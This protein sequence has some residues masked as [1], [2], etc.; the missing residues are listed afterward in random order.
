MPPVAAN[1]SRGSQKKSAS[2]NLS[3]TEAEQ[4]ILLSLTKD[5]AAV[6]DK[7]DILT[8]INPK[9][10]KLFGVDDIFVCRLH[11]NENTLNPVLRVGARVRYQ[12]PDFER[13]ISQN[14]PIHDGFIDTILNTHQ[15]LVFDI[16]EVNNWPHPPAYMKILSAAG[17]AESLSISLHHSG[18]TIGI[19][20]LW[21]GTKGTFTSR[22][23]KLI[24]NIA[25]NISIIIANI[26]Y[27]ENLQKR[28]SQNEILLSLS[29]EIASIRSKNDL[30][31]IIRDSIKKHVHFD[32]SYILRYDKDNH[33]CR[34]FIYHRTKNHQPVAE[35]EAQLAIDYPLDDTIA[36]AH[37]P[38]VYNVAELRQRGQQLVSFI[39]RQGIKE[40]VTIKLMHRNKIIG[41]LVLLSKKIASFSTDDLYLLQRISY[42]VSI[43]TANILANE[44]IEKREAEKSLLLSLSNDMAMVRNKE[45]LA[46]II[47][48]KLKKLFRI[49]DFTIVALHE[50][51]MTYGAYF[52]DQEDTPYKKKLEYVETLF[53]QFK[54][55][56]GLYDVVLSSEDP[57]VFNIGEIMQREQVPGHIRFFHSLGIQEIVGAA[58]RIGREDI[59]IL[60]IQPE[61]V[62]SFDTFN[63]RVF[64]GVSSQISIALANIIANENIQKR[65][66]EKSILL[67][68]SNE[69][70]AVRDKNGLFAVINSKV[71]ELFA[72]SGFAI[73][74]I[75]EDRKTHGAF[76]LDIEEQITRQAD[77]K[78]IIA[79]RYS[80]NDGVFDA[81]M[82]SMEPVTFNIANLEETPD[83]P[84][85]ASFWKK[86]GI[87]YIIG[88]PLRVG[89]NNMGCFYFHLGQQG[90]ET[91]RINLLKSVCSQLS[92]ALSNIISNEN[93]RKTHAENS[94]LLSFSN[95]LVT[96]KD[97]SGL[98]AIIKAYLKERFLIKE[99]IITVKNDDD[100]SYGYFLHDLQTDDPTDEGFKLITGPNMPIQGAMT[101]AVLQ[102]DEPV[103]FNLAEIEDRFS[104]PSA[105]FWRSTDAKE[106]M[107]MRL[108]I[109]GEDIGIL[110]TRPDQVTRRL[111]H[112]VSAQVAIA[113]S[114]II[115][116]EKN[117]NH[118]NEISNYKRQ[119]EDEKQYLQEEV[120]GSYT[121]SDII[122]TGPEMQ[123]LFRL[124]TQ[125][126]PSNSTVLLLGETGT[127]KEM[128]A[129]ALHNSSPRKNKLLVKVNCA[130]H[131]PNL[132]ESELFGHEKGSFTGATEL[133]IGKFE[134]ANNGTLFLDEIGEMPFDLQ[135]KLLRALQE[136]EIERVG[137]KV[138]IRTDVRIIAATNRDLQKEVLE[139]RFRSDL[140]YRLNVFPITL[141]PLRSRKEDIPLLAAHFIEKYARNA[142]KNIHS[143]S[144][145]VMNEL[146]AYNWP[147]NVREL[148]HL[149]ERSLLLTRGNTIKEIHLP[150]VG[151]KELRKTAE[152]GYIKTIDENERDHIL[153]VLKKC[154]GR[155]YGKAGAAELLGVP[156]S[157]LNS[158]I[159]K[160][161]L[162]K[163]P[164]FT[165]AKDNTER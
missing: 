84:A 152:D 23:K 86:S 122:G 128:V 137:G 4:E 112:G 103:I 17:I 70:A 90:P 164:V 88:V 64:K 52:Y 33:T 163:Q 14:L 83:S 91:I 132:V 81:V 57:V 53:N 75:S 131:P 125:V 44:D 123:K 40:L 110:W 149:I 8:I 7:K 48:R 161:G 126:S 104:F 144:Q 80:V 24:E 116:I 148:E 1:G 99:Y 98:R 6:R 153:E 36:D 68:I 9:L 106:I 71:K 55:E 113:I 143:I 118:L 25:D 67:S 102:S 139:G 39:Q 150:L 66:Y 121:Y 127:G 142:G 87:P 2:D 37:V 154:N 62:N 95:D 16:G 133:K 114:N 94:L 35:W 156:V 77:Y 78:E 54:F 124:L 19:L 111:L 73:A 21:A 11:P 45:D 92:V 82:R 130:S 72:I 160:L 31:H 20:S 85:Y 60:W 79:Q 146:I 135:V 18:N 108:R 93:I 141:P 165:I 46:K 15:P 27:D 69:I 59:G 22:H 12:H 136:K 29:N 65:E 49:K 129:R 10:K 3:F 42:Q 120:G 47:H 43:A 26:S 96:V 119:L 32:D 105:S 117:K 56:S 158:K 155:I 13:T 74:L 159:K 61:Q 115:A 51:S 134:L 147:G 38:F 100:A 138:I 76:L 97:R 145:K 34:A 63:Q 30:L 109:A 28:D 151:R 5:I 157:T 89:E 58:L 50:N 41:L 140:F 107:G 162:K 101:G